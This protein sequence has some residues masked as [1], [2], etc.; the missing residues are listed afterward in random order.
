MAP[1]TH[2][3]PGPRRV[4]ALPTPRVVRYA[5]SPPALVSTLT[6]VLVLGPAQADQLAAALA[7]VPPSEQRLRATAVSVQWW[8]RPWSAVDRPTG[9]VLLGSVDLDRG[10][11]APG[12]ASIRRS[13][14][15]AA[16]VSAGVTPL[17]VLRAVLVLAGL[18]VD[19]ASLSSP[20]P[21]V[22]DP[23]HRPTAEQATEIHLTR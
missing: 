11:P 23:F 19:E 5:A 21:A 14:V 17:A 12:Q 20:V 8:D 3:L 15:T 1:T 4:E 16:G 18:D 10:I 9:A 7:A 22:R 6:P 2:P 13:L